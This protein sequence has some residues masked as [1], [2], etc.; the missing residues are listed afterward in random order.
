MGTPP[1][2]LL[3]IDRLCP[4]YG[5]AM[6][7]DRNLRLPARLLLAVPVAALAFSLAACSASRPTVDQ[8]SDGLIKFF[9]SQDQ[10][11]VLTDDAADC[12][13]KHFVDSDLSNETLNYIA[14]GKDQASSTE[15]ATLTQKI[16]QDNYEECT[17]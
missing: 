15:D 2:S 11:D 16:L 5:V 4:A 7:I 10:G 3:S 1:H 6:N 14:Q 8:V 12:F 17:A 9:E 13:A